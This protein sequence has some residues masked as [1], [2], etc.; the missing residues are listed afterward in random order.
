ME[1]V[2]SYFNEAPE[3]TILWLAHTEELCA[4]AAASFKEIWRHIGKSPVRLYRCWGSHTPAFP[5]P[6]SSLVIGGFSKLHHLRQSGAQSPLANL[7]IIDEAHK[8]LAPTYAAIISWAKT[9]SSRVVGLSATPGRGIGVGEENTA[10]ADFF[11]NQ[12]IGIE[13]GGQGVIDFLQGRGILAR[14]EREVLLSNVTFHLDRD[15]W[16]KLEDELEYSRGFLKRVAENHER[17]KIII[18]RLW[19]LAQENVQV[20]GFAAS[21]E[22]SRL[23]CAMLLYRGIP[24]A[25]IDGNTTPETRRAVIAKFRR[26]EIK[27]LFNYE[28]LATGFDAPG[29]DVVFIAR[30][31]KSLVLYSQMIGRGMRGPAVGGTQS[32]RLIDVIDNIID[33]SGNLDDVYEYFADY[34]S[35]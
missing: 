34:W 29:I 27:F 12:I 7:I 25:H 17:N 22:Q 8:I 1:L 10:L 4:Q 19:G 14:A 18:G 20:L 24:A 26:G 3:R 11:N 5:T 2:A 6:P 35:E 15:E 30:P 31:T 28:V 21:V 16:Q 9:L 33:Y 13:A 23:L 32:V